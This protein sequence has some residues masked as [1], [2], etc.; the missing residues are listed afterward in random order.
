M[1]NDPNPGKYLVKI[2][3]S[4]IKMYSA[5]VGLQQF[6]ARGRE[7]LAAVALESVPLTYGRCGRCGNDGVDKA[8]FFLLSLKLKVFEFA[9]VVGQ[10]SQFGA[11]DFVSLV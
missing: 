1:V 6:L 2:V 10:K 9:Q 5:S 4:F 11:T 7:A 3:E 8:V